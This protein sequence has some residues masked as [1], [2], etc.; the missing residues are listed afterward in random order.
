VSLATRFRNNNEY[1]LKY[2]DSFISLLIPDAPL[3][4]GTIQNASGTDQDTIMRAVSNEIEPVANVD[5]GDVMF[6]DAGVLARDHYSE[7]SLSANGTDQARKII[8]KSLLLKKVAQ[9]TLR[10]C[11]VFELTIVFRWFYQRSSSI[12]P[13]QKSTGSS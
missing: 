5:R 13:L 10:S 4:A 6:K 3:A 9:A 7:R 2:A 8:P 11:L 12:K 1:F